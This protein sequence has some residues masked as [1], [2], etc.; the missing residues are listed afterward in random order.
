VLPFIM[1][2]PVG[3]SPA[4]F[5]VSMVLQTGTYFCGS[6][7]VRMLLPRFGAFRLVFVGILSVCVSSVL[8]ATLTRFTSP[9]L[10]TVMGPVAVYALGVA[11][12]MPAMQTAAL[13][14]FPRIAGSASAMA[15][16]LQMGTGLL[17]GSITAL[18]P[19][20]VVAMSTVIPCLGGMAVISWLIWRRLPE[21]ALATAVN[22]V[23]GGPG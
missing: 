12:V 8:M 15:G 11:F 20:P 5:G 2:G 1:M 9:S 4:Q 7:V 6:L 3:F 10:A 18:I 19:D 17:G 13:A 21:P 14:P 16:F 23:P 22:S